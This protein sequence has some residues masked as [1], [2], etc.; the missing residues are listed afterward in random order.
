MAS[1]HLFGSWMETAKCC[2]MG[3]DQLI[4]NCHEFAWQGSY[5]QYEIQF[6]FKNMLCVNLWIRQELLLGVSRK[7]VFCVHAYIR[8][9]IHTEYI[10]TCESLK[11]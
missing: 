6:Y 9:Y 3:I 8:A 1:L 5:G 10:H 2:C 11:E 7:Q 4:S